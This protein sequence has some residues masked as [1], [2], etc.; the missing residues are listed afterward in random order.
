MSRT[1]LSRLKEYINDLKSETD[2]NPGYVTEVMNK[3]Y[4]NRPNPNFEFPDRSIHLSEN[5][6]L[7]IFDNRIMKSGLEYEHYGVYEKDNI[8]YLFRDQRGWFDQLH[9]HDP[10]LFMLRLGFRFKWPITFVFEAIKPVHEIDAAPKCVEDIGRFRYS[11]EKFKRPL[12]TV[13][14]RREDEHKIIPDKLLAYSSYTER[15]SPI[16][17]QWKNYSSGIIPEEKELLDYNVSVT[18]RHTMELFLRAFINPIDEQTTEHI[19]SLFI[20]N[21]RDEQPD[22]RLVTYS[23]KETS[24]R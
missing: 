18:N 16:D 15:R 8:E 23:L 22:F 7:V 13:Y 3:I 4:Y 19:T 20:G 2:L 21:A 1:S 14:Y 5:E 9:P 17:G 6:S 24:S 10:E 11:V 12:K